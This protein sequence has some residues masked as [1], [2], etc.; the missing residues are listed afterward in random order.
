MIGQIAFVLTY[1]QNS[2]PDL[3]TEDNLRKMI[4]AFYPKSPAF[5]VPYRAE[6]L[7]YIKTLDAN[8]NVIED[9]IKCDDNIY[10]IY[11]NLE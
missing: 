2:V 11:L 7:E 4:E 6:D 10:V 5:V 9:I 3:L 1:L 8:I